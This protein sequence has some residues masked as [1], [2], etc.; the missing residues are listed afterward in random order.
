MTKNIC[1]LLGTLNDVR[2]DISYGE[3]GPMLADMDLE[4]LVSEL[5]DYLTQVTS[6]I[7]E[8]KVAA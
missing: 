6:L 7:D 3:P 1:E 2:K 5:E 4:D 8:V